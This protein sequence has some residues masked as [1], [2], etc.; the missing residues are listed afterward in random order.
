M[1]GDRDVGIVDDDRDPG[2]AF[3]DAGGHAEPCVVRRKRPAVLLA[4][5]VEV[6]AVLAAEDVNAGEPAVLDGLDP[7]VAQAE[8][9]LLEAA[10]EVPAA[11]AFAAGERAVR[12]AV[13]EDA[14]G[15]FEG[16]ALRLVRH[17]QHRA[18]VVPFVADVDG[19]AHGGPGFLQ[20]GVAVVAVGDQLHQ[21][22]LHRGE[23]AGV[24]PD[25]T[26]VHLDFGNRHGVSLTRSPAAA[27]PTGAGR[28]R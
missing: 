6:A 10:A 1:L 5:V 16:H 25:H 4:V 11:I 17:H 22:L 3:G 15:R 7:A 9:G 28:C 21:R 19:A 13:S 8:D 18:V 20:P 27:P 2:A 14:G 12:A 23:T 24:N 26:L